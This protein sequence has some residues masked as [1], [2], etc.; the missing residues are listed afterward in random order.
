[1]D[2]STAV[3]SALEDAVKTGPAKPATRAAT[4]KAALDENRELILKAIGQG[5]SATGLAKKLKASGLSAS[6]ESL[7]QAL[8]VI[9]STSANGAKAKATKTRSAPPTTT[10]SITPRTARATENK[11]FEAEDRTA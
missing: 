3:R 11:A 5:Y 9:V 2:V 6:V 4:L 1:M 8:Q 7:R 10:R